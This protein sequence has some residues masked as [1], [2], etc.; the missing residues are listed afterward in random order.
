MSGSRS[1]SDI[2]DAVEDGSVAVFAE[3]SSGLDGHLEAGES[4]GVTNLRLLG[5]HI[6][7]LAELLDAEPATV[8]QDALRALHELEQHSVGVIQE[9]DGTG[10]RRK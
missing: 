10:N 8:A 7:T 3:T 5:I 2:L 6:A 4:P 9:F 1:P